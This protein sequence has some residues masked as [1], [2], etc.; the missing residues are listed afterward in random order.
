MSWV[1]RAIKFHQDNAPSE[2]MDDPDTRFTAARH[3]AGH[4][5]VGESLMPGSVKN[6]G[7]S[8]RGGITT[9][10]LG[11]AAPTPDSLR[12]FSA[13]SLAGGLSEPGGTTTTHSSGDMKARNRLTGQMASTPMA[14]IHRI[15]TG[16]AGKNDPMLQAPEVQAEGQA[17]ANRV[18]VDP[19][20]Q[21]KIG[22]VTTGLQMRGKLT[23][24]QVR[25]LVR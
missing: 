13:I 14:N 12:D 5:V 15:I 1:K 3:E 4:A 7:L 17:R 20:I 9:V 16:G 18:L 19:V 25:R 10:D 24:D 11:D 23:G 22:D 2:S 6:M 21:Q 8:P